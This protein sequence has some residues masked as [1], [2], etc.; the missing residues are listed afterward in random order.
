[1]TAGSAFPD[2]SIRDMVH[3]Q[4]RLLSEQLRLTGIHA[5][6]GVSMG[7]LQTFEWMM[8]YPGYARHFVAIEGTPWPTHF[9]SLL[10][11][12]WDLALQL[13]AND[14]SQTEKA[15]SLLAA[16]DALTLWTPEYVMREFGAQDFPT[17]FAGLSE[18][19]DTAYLADRAS[20][21]R[22]I[23]GHDIRSPLA[24]ADKRLREP[25]PLSVLAVTFTADLMVNPAPTRQLAQAMKFPVLEVPGDCGHMG[26]NPECYQDAVAVA[27]NEF[28][29]EGELYPMRRGVMQHDGI[30][31]EYFVYVPLKQQGG[32]PLPVVLALHGYGVTA[33]GF[34]AYRDINRH[35]EAN[36]YMVIYPQG[37]SFMGALGSDPAAE[38]FL[39]TSWNDLAANFTPTAS[40]PHCTPDRL[41]YPC[42]PECG[43]CNHCAWVSCYDDL[44]FLHR[45]LDEV[46]AEYP[47]DPE[48]T[49]LL[50]VSNGAAMAMR[51]SCDRPGRFAAT[52]ALLSQMPPGHD[53]TPARS[54][55]LL[56]LYG[57]QDDVVG[58]DGSATSDGWIYVSVPDTLASWKKN[59]A[60]ADEPV[61]WHTAATDA[62]GL[63][64]SAYGG[65]REPGHRVVSCRDP[66]AGHIWRAQRLESIPPNCVSAEHRAS[67][68]Q[69][70]VCP[71]PTAQREELRGME[72]VWQFLSQY[73][74]QQPG[75]GG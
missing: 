27:V 6:V 64:C 53:C 43:S 47:A 31:R 10:W 42:P 37:S 70:P 72:M 55:P 44:G 3:A 75:P 66:Q 36:G 46:Q 40:G 14:P 13:A 2:F 48:R 9:D 57:E 34:Q 61:A 69:Q 4:H 30:E 35:A 50:G 28:L 60:C 29:A 5:V 12:A 49:Y 7:A 18:G 25:S 8:Q 54:L 59:M 73:S 1:V 45:V 26:P 38:K 58:H 15:A 22:A 19:M 33:T 52:A 65:C 24:A 41:Q 71:A 51:V 11:N 21:T 16:L 62:A 74:R 20:Q 17:F 23:L 39:V 68:Q 63:S 56:H 32:R 67:L